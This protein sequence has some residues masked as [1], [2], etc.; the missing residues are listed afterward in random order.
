MS[1]KPNNGGG[2]NVRPSAAF[3]EKVER[4]SEVLFPKWSKVCAVLQK[5]DSMQKHRVELLKSESSSS[6]PSDAMAEA[7]KQ[8][9]GLLDEVRNFRSQISTRVE[10]LVSQARESELIIK[11]MERTKVATKVTIVQ[12]GGMLPPDDQYGSWEYDSDDDEGRGISYLDNLDAVIKAEKAKIGEIMDE[13]NFE[14]TIDKML[15][16]DMS[17]FAFKAQM[18]SVEFSDWNC[19][20]DTP[21]YTNLPMV[22]TFELMLRWFAKKFWQA[23]K[24]EEDEQ[25]HV[26][27]AIVEVEVKEIMA[28]A[29]MTLDKPFIPRCF[30]CKEEGHVDRECP[31]V[32]IV[33]ENG[34][35]KEG[36]YAHLANRGQGVDRDK[37]KFCTICNKVGH[38]DEYCPLTHPEEEEE[39][40][41]TCSYCGRTGHMVDG[42]WKV[43][44][45]LRRVYFQK[46]K[47]QVCQ[48][49]RKSDHL[50]KYCPDG[51]SYKY[52]LRP[53]PER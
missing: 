8:T 33:E 18:V 51:N 20:S 35:N 25:R 48:N 40:E 32:D 28:L 45:E 22:E 17:E 24:E 19:D 4:L 49:C 36:K 29:T 11:D 13:I 42:C 52:G 23:V 31:K 5:I 14:A 6:Q 39:E 34:L 43:H 50:T 1:A 3:M 21:L 41:N 44:P 30:T 37:P 46:R 16:M 38:V 7:L 12:Q 47:A 9:S 15:R 26:K 2:N 10:S 53:V 27:K